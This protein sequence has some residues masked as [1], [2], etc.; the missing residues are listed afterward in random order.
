MATNNESGLSDY[1]ANALGG[2]WNLERLSSIIFNLVSAVITFIILDLS[3]IDPITNSS[4]DMKLDFW[5]SKPQ[6]KNDLRRLEELY[7]KYNYK[8][9]GHNYW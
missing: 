2:G 5:Y 8:K 3:K 6:D 9:F 1:F 4:I 7:L